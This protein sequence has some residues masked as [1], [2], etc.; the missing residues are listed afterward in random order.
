MKL[1]GQ[2]GVGVPKALA[3]EDDELV[4]G[5]VIREGHEA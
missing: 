5:G 1:R 3:Q 4:K 2:D